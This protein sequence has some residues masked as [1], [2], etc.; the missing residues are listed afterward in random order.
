ME[1]VIVFFAVTVLV[2][3]LLYEQV[4]GRSLNALII[5]YGFLLLGMMLMIEYVWLVILAFWAVR[6]TWRMR[7]GQ[8][9]FLPAVVGVVITSAHLAGWKVYGS[10][11]LHDNRPLFE[12]S[13]MLDHLEMPNV[14]VASDGSRHALK[15]VRWVDKPEFLSGENLHML[16]SSMGGRHLRFVPSS[17]PDFASG[18]AVEARRQIF[19]GNSFFPSFFPRTIPAYR[20]ED[21]A[22]VLRSFIATSVLAESH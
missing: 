19:C 7:S 10:P 13:L 6:L 9:A 3:L 14:M 4:S 12:S 2:I 8:W 22:R 1:M 11:G 20:K 16:A 17:E 15:G 5:S 21:A 18:Y